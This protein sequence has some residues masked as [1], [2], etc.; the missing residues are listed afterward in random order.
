MLYKSQSSKDPISILFSKRKSCAPELWM[1]QILHDHNSRHRTNFGDRTGQPKQTP[2]HQSLI[3]LQLATC[4]IFRASCFP[5]LDYTTHTHY[6]AM[7]FNNAKRLRRHSPT[8]GLSW[9][10]TVVKRPSAPPSSQ[11][12]DILHNPIG[13]PPLLRSS[14]MGVDSL[15]ALAAR[16]LVGNLELLEKESLDD[17]PEML[18][19][20]V[21]ELI[22]E[23]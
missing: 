11:L 23:R 22:E 18:V 8:S 16:C 15:E 9:N 4:N 21:W 3:N 12:R 5:A 6:T 1:R 14:G 17:V 13:V 2:I 7:S 10:E 19:H 20:K